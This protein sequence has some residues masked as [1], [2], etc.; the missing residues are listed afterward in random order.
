MGMYDTITVWP[1]DR[2]HCA[3]GHALGDLQ[4]KSLECLMHRYIVFD[5][6]LYHVL[7]D[8]GETVVASES[9]R[10]VMRRTS[11]ME[12]ERRTTTVLAYTHC[13]SCRPVLYLGGRSAWADEVSERDPWAEW[14]LELVDG[15]LVDL[16]PVKLETRDD[17]RAALRKE[18]LEVLDDDERLARLHFA[19]RSEPEAR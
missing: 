1:R 9:G 5:G 3:E 6:A 8:D 18:G 15:R 13:G 2:T 4:T 16:V 14:Q 17:I 12:E 7:E 10:P 19:R 11:R